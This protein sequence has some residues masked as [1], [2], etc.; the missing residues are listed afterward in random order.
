MILGV[1]STRIPGLHEGT[2][3]RAFQLVDAQ[4][5][6]D[7]WCY[8]DNGQRN[9]TQLKYRSSEGKTQQTKGCVLAHEM[10]LGKTLIALSAIAMDMFEVRKLFK[11]MSTPPTT[12]ALFVL[13]NTVLWN[14]TSEIAK[15][16]P[17]K[18]NDCQFLKI[19]VYHR[20]NKEVKLP[21]T[22][23]ELLQYDIVLTTFGTFE[24]RFDL[25]RQHTWEY[26][27]VDEAHHLRNKSTS[28]F[29][30]IRQFPSS[31]TL[32]LT[33]T[34]ISNKVD[35]LCSL[36]DILGID[37]RLAKRVLTNAMR[38]EKKSALDKVKKHRHFVLEDDGSLQMD[39][40]PDDDDDDDDTK[41]TPTDN[42]EL[43]F[44]RKLINR[45]VIRRRK[46]DTNDDGTP[47][48]NL[49]AKVIKN[50]VK[51]LDGADLTAYQAIE[52]HLQRQA[53][54]DEERVKRGLMEKSQLSMKFLAILNQMRM[55]ASHARMLRPVALE[56][57]V[58]RQ[59]I[60]QL[61]NV[62]SKMNRALE[63]IQDLLNE[64]EKVV[65]FS[66]WVKFLLPLSEELTKRLGVVHCSSSAALLR[67]DVSCYA[68]ID[69]TVADLERHNQVV[70]F[71]TDPA[72]KVF[73]ISLQAGAEGIT[74]TKSSNVII[75][76][77]WWNPQVIE[78]AIDRVHRLGQNKE[79]V[80]RYLVGVF[81]FCFFLLSS[82]FFLLSSFF[83]LLSVRISLLTR[84][85]S[86]HLQSYQKIRLTSVSIS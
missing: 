77:P 69:G 49:P 31:K 30:L 44:A 3:L 65:L 25:F 12:Q 5:V 26:L 81:S 10:G 20:S 11:H 32:L 38:A 63:I 75:C 42:T 61:S 45:C 33:G 21:T 23:E 55:A 66:Q 22:P 83:F 64:G 4:R 36:I 6:V 24:S 86:F 40:I 54:T 56:A 80:V 19:L 50:N 74:L 85:C 37:A 27:C 58:P 52:L 72:C 1:D 14:W 7:A 62:S 39:E 70:R 16:F 2:R 17:K 48:L 34:P 18:N 35:D 79:V 82:L 43:S 51:K 67:S 47:I 46:D 57:M 68:Q 78:Q 76:D 41:R 53:R 13:P 60:A 8:L 9:S 28:G 59:V 29:Q 15:F 73:L 71:Q 84:S